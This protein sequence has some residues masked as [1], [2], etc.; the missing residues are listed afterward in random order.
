MAK[1]LKPIHLIFL[2]CIY[3]F[4]PVSLQA[5]GQ[6]VALS[7]GQL[8]YVPA[9]SHI[10]SGNQE[11]PFL[12]TVTLSIRNIDPTHQI[13]I[14]VADYYETQGRLLKKFINNPLT[15]KPLESERYVIPQRDESGGSGANFIVE[16]VSEQSVYEPITEAVMIETGSQQGISFVSSGRVVSQTP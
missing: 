8:I 10:Y 13:H 14:S 5:A 15:L 4:S 2:I 12:L 6:K 3:L 11:R 16:W 1:R 9:Y 7:K